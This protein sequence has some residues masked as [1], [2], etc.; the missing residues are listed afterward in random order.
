MIAARHPRPLNARS[1]PRRPWNSRRPA[2]LTLPLIV[3]TVLAVPISATASGDAEA[4]ERSGFFVAGVAELPEYQGADDG[5][6]VPFFVGQFEL[7]RGTV[8]LEGLEARLDLIDGPWRG[9]PSLSVGLPRDEDFVDEP[10]IQ[11]LPEVDVA[12]EL[13]GFVGLDVPL[14]R[15]VEDRL[16]LDLAVR[17]DVLDAHGGLTAKFKV[18]Y[19]FKVSRMLRIGLAANST[20]ADG[21]YHETYFSIA[22]E[23]AQDAGLAIYDAGAGFRDFGFEVYAITSFSESWGVFTRFA[24]NRLVDD[25]AES[26]LV[27]DLGS[28]DQ[29][30]FGAGAFYRW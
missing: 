28:R 22:P 19:F 23:A 24:W 8:E 14:G 27:R 1:V 16:R 3:A 29:R 11:L 17:H 5:R 18:E 7:D 2:I 10:T 26:P 21:G 25:A 13:G 6:L 4:R 30:F 9:G 20:W 12:L 15:S